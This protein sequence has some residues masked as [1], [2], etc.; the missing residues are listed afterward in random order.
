MLNKD[1]LLIFVISLLLLI[2]NWLAF[3]DFYEPHSVRDWLM[4]IASALVFLKFAGEF[5]K[6][7]FKQ[8]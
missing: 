8:A 2:V 4:L 3:H 6:Q 1:N 7:H 5:W